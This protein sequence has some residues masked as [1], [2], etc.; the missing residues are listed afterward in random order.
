M[1]EKVCYNDNSFLSSPE[2]EWYILSIYKDLLC[3]HYDNLPYEYSLHIMP[4][5]SLKASFLTEK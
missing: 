5:N 1:R 3:P 4:S 2:R